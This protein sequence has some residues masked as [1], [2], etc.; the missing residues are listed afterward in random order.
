MDA[1]II[2]AVIGAVSG[3]A[4]GIVGSLV[5]PWVHWGIE[6]RRDLRATRREL[7]ASARAYVSSVRFGAGQFSRRSMFARLKPYLSP[8]NV[9]AIE[10]PDE[11]QDQMDNPGEFR[12]S[13]RRGILEDLQRIEKEWELL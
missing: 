3:L 11:V 5:A 4:A 1:N 9:R 10:N 7:L 6:K 8:D 12:E 13:L 2:T